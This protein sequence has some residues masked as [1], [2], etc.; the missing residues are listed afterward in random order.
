M[1]LRERDVT[2]SIFYSSEDKTILLSFRIDNLSKI[3]KFRK[4]S[5]SDS[6]KVKIL[7]RLSI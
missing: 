1:I 6:V 7:N 2:S 4:S 5:Y 3:K